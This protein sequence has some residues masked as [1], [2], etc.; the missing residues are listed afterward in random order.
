MDRCWERHLAS[1]QGCKIL[2]TTLLDERL[3]KARSFYFQSAAK[4]QRSEFCVNF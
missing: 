3:G 2:D 1:N 4:T